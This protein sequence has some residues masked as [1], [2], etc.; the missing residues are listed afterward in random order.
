MFI[1]RQSVSWKYSVISVIS[2]SNISSYLQYSCNILFEVTKAHAGDYTCTPY[3]IHGTT[4]TSGIMQVCRLMC[5]PLSSSVL[6][7]LYV[8]SA[9]IVYHSLRMSKLL[10]K[11]FISLLHILLQSRIITYVNFIQLLFYTEI[12]RC[13]YSTNDHVKQW[14]YETECILLMNLP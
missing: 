1:F 2:F 4:G 11:F 7:A 14:F 5:L 10:F 8:Y 6:S 3:N 9:I 13:M 12:N